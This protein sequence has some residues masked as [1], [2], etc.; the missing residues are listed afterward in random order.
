MIPGPG[1]P[2]GGPPPPSKDLSGPRREAAKSDDGRSRFTERAESIL[3]ALAD[4]ARLPSPEETP[5]PRAVG[6]D[7]PSPERSLGPDRGDRASRETEDRLS[8]V[9]SRGAGRLEGPKG[10]P[11]SDLAR[12]RQSYNATQTRLRAA[13][14][15][16]G[17][18][19]DFEV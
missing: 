5:P 14:Q 13:A 11:V 6:G 17:S 12:T 3:A 4:A 2:A 8:F 10:D 7:G 16:P 15:P 18:L 1:A 9:P 19:L